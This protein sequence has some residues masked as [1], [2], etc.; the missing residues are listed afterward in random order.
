MGDFPAFGKIPRLKREVVITEKIDGT[1]GLV[2]VYG[3]E[4]LISNSDSLPNNGPIT[5]SGLMVAAG[6][7]KRWIHPD[8]DNHGFAR[9]VWDHAE[10][11]VKLGSGHHY[12][13][14]WGSGINRG[15][16]LNKGEKR[17]SLFN[18]DRWVDADL[19]ECV[20][21]VPTLM[22]GNA[23]EL[24]WMV[25]QT[26]TNLSTYGSF[27]APW[28]MKPEGIVVYHTAANQLFKVTLEGDEAPESLLPEGVA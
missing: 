20:G 15:Y 4:D 9:W 18:V 2:R 1:N 23:S 17:F 12:G 27:A 21:V 26:L 14:W 22:R 7:R 5:S 28:F 8:D 10:E 25:E 3:V 11:L 13:E 16:G 19:P 24:G 6:S